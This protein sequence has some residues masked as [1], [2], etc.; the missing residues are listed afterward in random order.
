VEEDAEVNEHAIR[1]ALGMASCLLLISCGGDD[2]D[3]NE[4]V[5]RNESILRTLPQPPGSREDTSSS[6]PYYRESDSD[7]PIGHTTEIA[8]VAPRGSKGS[9]VIEFY[10]RRIDPPWHCQHEP[11]RV[12]DLGRTPRR[13]SKRTVD[14]VLNCTQGRA[15]VSVN[16]DRMTAT[17]PQFAVVADWKGA[18]RV[19]D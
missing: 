17:P 14:G 10:A 3:K 2:T 15:A 7:K 13:A 9:D 16:V 19:P 18:L 1:A 11:T 5:A 8:Y 12:L 6:T 4:D